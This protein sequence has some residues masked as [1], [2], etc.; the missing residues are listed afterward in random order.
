[1]QLIYTVLF[2]QSLQYLVQALP[3]FLAR[4]LHDVLALRESRV[5]ESG[6]HSV[7]R[8]KLTFSTVGSAC[9][10]YFLIILGV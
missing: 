9:D 8:N 6:R 4:E 5:V 2:C 7:C 1:M 10:N 3:F